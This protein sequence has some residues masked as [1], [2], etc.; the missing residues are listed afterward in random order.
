MEALLQADEVLRDI[1]PKVF[2]SADMPECAMAL[3]AMDPVRCSASFR[4]AASMLRRLRSGVRAHRDLSDA[5]LWCEAAAWAAADQDAATM[6][7]ALTRLAGAIS[8]A[9]QTIH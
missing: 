4:R 9:G 6:H 3:R 8:A 5:L 2:D 7:E 1:V